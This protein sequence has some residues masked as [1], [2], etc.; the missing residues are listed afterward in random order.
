MKACSTS[1][2]SQAWKNAESNKKA[3]E[4]Q[5]I[6][7]L[8]YRKVKMVEIMTIKIY[9]GNLTRYIEGKENGGWLQ[10]PMNEIKLQ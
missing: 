7:R 5:Y 1:I 6:Y 10:L 2:Q 8:I 4:N 3:I 9:L